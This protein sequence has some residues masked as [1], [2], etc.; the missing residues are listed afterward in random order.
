MRE[1]E[2]FL[3]SFFITFIILEFQLYH[4]GEANRL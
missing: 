2:S 3:K 4:K 1:K